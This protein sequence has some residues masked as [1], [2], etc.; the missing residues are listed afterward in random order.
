MS[1]A[2]SRGARDHRRNR[3]QNA[4]TL[5]D[6]QDVR[7]RL[8]SRTGT[9][10]AF[11]YELML[12][13]SRNQV[14]ASV[15]VPLLTIVVAAVAAAWVDWRQAAV[16]AAAVLIGEA[17]LLT[18]CRRFERVSPEEV[19]IA[20]WQRVFMVAEC[21]YGVAWAA[22][23]VLSLPF[24][25][26]MGES[27]VFAV[28]VVVLAIRTMVASNC[29]RAFF[30]GTLPIT[31]ALVLRFGLGLQLEALAMALIAVCAQG[32]FTLLAQRLRATAIAMFSFRAEKDA[33]I[34]ELEQEKSISDE[35][36]RRAEDANI[37]KSRF[38]ATMSHELRTPLNAILGFSEVMKDELFGP[39]T[40]PQYRDYAE[41][42]HRSGRHL[43]D[44][45]SEILDLSRIEAGRY[46]LN[47]EAVTLV[48]TVEDCVHLVSLRAREKGLQIVEQYEDGMARLW[49]DERAV[50]QVCLNLLSNAVKFTP[51]GGTITV[52][53]G[54]TQGGGQYIAVRDTGPGIPEEEI[55]I[56]LRSFG[57]GSL[58]QKTAEDGAGLGLP[59]VTGLVELHGG[60]FELK[61]KLRVGTE[62]IVS[63]PRSRV[64]HALP[65]M[66]VKPRAA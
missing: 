60:R 51:T 20:S 53:C 17:V 61:S 49:A 28:L 31:A 32:Y 57:Q 54:W 46:Q 10:P 22:L 64:M 14:S 27:F 58:A 43:L 23:T 13:F 52:L 39:H 29:L 41:D 6:L 15:T 16:W 2:L 47:E 65:P 8:M 59:I 36:R 42:I 3:R 19:R 18:L 30:A 62:A 37:A 40:S 21:F 11:D 45:I 38:L 5:T 55:P 63:F 66:E 35:A 9:K 50:R 33:L 1:H 24:T 48:H 7:D 26:S 4:R 12:M 44:L 34:A 56:V 25:T